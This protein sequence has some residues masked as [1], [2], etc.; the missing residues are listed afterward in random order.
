MTEYVTLWFGKHPAKITRKQ[1]ER[2]M[3]SAGQVNDLL[4]KQ[5]QQSEPKTDKTPSNC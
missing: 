4:R 5:L 3:K 1:Y 2:A